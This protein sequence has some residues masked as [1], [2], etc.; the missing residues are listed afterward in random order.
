M[1]NKI[2]F[3]KYLAVLLFSLGLSAQQVSV[4][5]S[6]VEYINNGQSKSFVSGCGAIDLK[7]STSTLIEMSVNVSTTTSVINNSESQ[8][9]VY[10]KISPSATT[11]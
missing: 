2:Y 10:S 5:P 4:T 7:Y 9:Y 8:L 6:N 1:I 3:I 11:I